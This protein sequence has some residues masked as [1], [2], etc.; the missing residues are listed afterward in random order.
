MTVSVTYHAR[1]EITDAMG[2]VR[3]V[4]NNG[5]EGATLSDADVVADLGR[6]LQNETVAL[7][8]AA[9][10]YPDFRLLW[11]EAD[12]EL[13]VE[14]TCNDGGSE[15]LFVVK[16]QAHR[17]LVLGDD[18]SRHTDVAGDLFA[19]TADVIDKIRVK[20]PNDTAVNLRA[21]LVR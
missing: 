11:L 16:L 15:E 17:P 20:E 4:R 14:L 13:E 3:T 2:D 6:A 21:I 19:G 8:D 12:G 10:L 18:A 5:G 1:L 7:W 9:G